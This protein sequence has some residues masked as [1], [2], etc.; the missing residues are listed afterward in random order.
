[1]EAF[2]HV[3]YRVDPDAE[4]DERVRRLMNFRLAADHNTRRSF[5]VMTSQ[6]RP[7]AVKK[8]TAKMNRITDSGARHHLA[9][10]FDRKDRQPPHLGSPP[11]P[12]MT[13]LCDAV[14]T[15]VDRLGTLAYRALC[16]VAH[17][18]VHGLASHFIEPI[19]L[20]GDKTS[21]DYVA[22][23]GIDSRQAA[24]ML[25]A[26]P[27]SAVTASQSLLPPTGFDTE[28]LAATSH[29][30]VTTWARIGQMHAPPETG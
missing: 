30:M 15:H 5:Q 25:A 26:A 7:E 13:A 27:I 16:G 12:T 18:Q 8:A 14:V 24:V 6:P 9:P 1:M 21:G 2:A 22:A 23:L 28:A 11:P 17:S 3:H 4:L 19:P 20:L 10:H 29:H